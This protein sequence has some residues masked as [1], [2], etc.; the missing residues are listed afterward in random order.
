VLV[1]AV[2]VTIAFGL[3][4]GL[5]FAFVGGLAL[6]VIAQRPLGASTFALLLCVGGA[7]VLARSFA[8]LRPI[9]P[10]VA[11]FL[12]SIGYSMILFLA[13]GAL[14]TPLPVSDP[15]SVILPGAIYDAV[16]A[17]LIGPL[18]IAIHDRRVDQERVD[19]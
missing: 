6:D 19:W 5:I 18:V 9:V 2:V 14:G 17:L 1:L 13:L 10:V 7:A 16:L 4:A 15:L 11:V 12:L 8:R 3:D